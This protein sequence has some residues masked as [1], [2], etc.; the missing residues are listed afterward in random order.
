LSSSSVTWV[1]HLLV[2]ADRVSSSHV[3]KFSL[4]RISESLISLL[5]LNKFFVCKLLFSGVVV[6]MKLLGKLSVFRLEG[7]RVEIFGHSKNVVITSVLQ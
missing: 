1:L 6:W 5:H 7:F 2:L 4:L 3:I